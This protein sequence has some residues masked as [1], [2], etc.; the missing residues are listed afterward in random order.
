LPAPRIIS[1]SFELAPGKRLLKPLDR[2]SHRCPV[3]F[4]QLVEL[5]LALCQLSPT[6]VE[7]LIVEG[8]GDV[9]VVSPGEKN[10]GEKGTQLFKTFCL[11]ELRPLSFPGVGPV[12]PEKVC[13]FFT[14]GTGQLWIFFGY[15][16][17]FQ[18]VPGITGGVAG[19][20]QPVGVTV[21]PLPPGFL[22][23]VLPTIPGPPPGHLEIVKPG[24]GAQLPP[25]ILDIIT[26]GAGGQ[27]PGMT[28]GFF[29][30]L[31]PPKAY[32]GKPHR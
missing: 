30:L 5:T 29:D 10:P 3:S 9:V 14:D 31:K 12:N 13:R 27:F 21:G 4:P 18:Q 22:S 8:A 28:G 2:G 11:K 20:G 6:G 25:G 17:G 23:G 19:A 26:P 7:V 16:P 24:T 15:G 32:L 1:S